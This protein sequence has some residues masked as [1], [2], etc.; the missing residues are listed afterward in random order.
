METSPGAT[1]REAKG[2]YAVSPEALAERGRRLHD[3]YLRADPFPHIVI[4]D[5]F[6][7]EVL[8]GI[9]REFPDP[10]AIDWQHFD[11]GTEKKLASKAEIQLGE[12][13]RGFIW[14]L[15][16]QVF[17]SFLEELTGIE[18]LI[19][20]P[21]LWG[22]GLH[23]IVRGGFLKVHADFNRNEKL[24]LDR[25]LNLLLYLNRDWKEDYGGHL[26]LWT[27]DMG[28]C[29]QR[30]LPVFNRCVVFSTT[31]FSYHGHPDPLTCPEGRT[32][33]SIAMYY[34]TNGRP[35]EEIS[36]DHSTLFQ[37]RPG[38][39]FVKRAESSSLR[40][41]VRDCI[42]PVLLRASRRLRGKA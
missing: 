12:R 19:P 13:T 15:N 25:R 8:D 29:V 30:I 16:S 39:A 34:Y 4:D 10:G 18:G 14:G 28:R 35:A 26:Q 20:D 42:P 36:G 9:L 32:R 6:P 40:N 3:A 41:L 2:G 21:H 1:G 7:E 38:E 23:Q 11:A 5:F 24:R 22:G 31:D 17:V 27:R 37:P 33:K